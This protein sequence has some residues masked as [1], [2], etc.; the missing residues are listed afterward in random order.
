MG[1]RI[2]MITIKLNA[3]HQTDWP[4]SDD[5]LFIHTP[6]KNIW[7]QQNIFVDKAPNLWR[8][9]IVSSLVQLCWEMCK[10]DTSDS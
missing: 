8:M 6:N 3:E 10:H 5:W 9:S 1:I 4:V 7:T 2:H